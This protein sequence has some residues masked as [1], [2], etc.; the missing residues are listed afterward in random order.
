M[1]RKRGRDPQCE[2]QTLTAGSSGRGG[3]GTGE[4]TTEHGIPGQNKKKRYV[5]K[6][7]VEMRRKERGEERSKK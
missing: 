6:S 1:Y 7:A 4:K 2:L 3:S 5:R